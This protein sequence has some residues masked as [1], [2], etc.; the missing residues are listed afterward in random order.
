MVGG[1]GNIQ[2]VEYVQN[3]LPS[4]GQAFNQADLSMVKVCVC[5]CVCVCVVLHI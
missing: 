3:C 5:V 2:L 1:G 4:E